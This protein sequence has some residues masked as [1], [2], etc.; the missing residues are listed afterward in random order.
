MCPKSLSTQ[1]SSLISK[2]N[3]GFTLITTIFIIVILSILTG[4]IVGIAGLM[5][6]SGNLTVNGV[7]AYYAAR[8]G[9]EWG[10]IQV[11]PVSS[12]PAS[13]P[14]SSPTTLN[15]TQQGLNGYTV[16][17]SCS[18]NSYSEAGATV[19]IFQITSVATFGSATSS[20]YAS[21]TLVEIVNQG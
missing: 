17:V 1:K 18:M 14:F 12:P 4:F 11:A 19:R 20:D 7:R 10:V 9:L 3:S 2:K 5:R 15:L 16:A 13:C 8:A 21:R 6:Q